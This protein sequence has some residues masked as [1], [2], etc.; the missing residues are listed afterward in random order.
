MNKKRIIGFLLTVLMLVPI[1]ATCV[2]AA[3]EVISVGK[4][5]T[6]EYQTPIHNAYPNKE[7]KPE[8]GLTDG[9]TAAAAKYSDE[10]W[11]E[12]YRGTAVEVTIDLESVMAVT[13]VTIGE[14]QHKSAGIVCSRYLEVYVS[15]NGTDFGFA[16][17]TENETLITDNYTKRVEL[18]ATLDKAYKARYVKV[19]FSSDIFT[20]VDEISVYGSSDS[21]DAA[22]AEITKP[23][24]DKGISGDIDGIKSVCLMYSVSTDYTPELLKPYVAYVDATGKVQ[25]TMFDSLLFLGTPAPT[26]NNGTTVQAD[27]VGFVTRT[28]AEGKNVDALND[29]IGELKNELD[30]GDDY[31][32]PIFISVPYIE[33]YNGA[34][35]EIDGKTVGANDLASR[36]AIVKWYIDYVEQVYSA[37]GYD[38]LELKGFYWMTEAINYHLS[39]HES[40]LAKYFNDYSHEKGYKTMWIPYYSSAG[41][42]EAMDLGFDSVTMQSGYAFDGGEEVGQAKAEVCDDAAAVAKKLGF[43]GIEFEIDVFKTNFAKRFAKYVSAAYHAG[44]MENGM[45]TMYQVGDNLYKSA[46]NTQGVG[47]EVYDLTYEYISGKYFEAVPVIKEGASVTLAVESFANGRL[48]VTDDDNKKNELKIIYVEKP[49]GIF[50]FAEGNGY[51]EVQSFGSQP[52]EYVAK[53]AVTD[54]SNI[55]NTVEIKITVEGEASE[56]SE[57][58]GN[59][60]GDEEKSPLGIIIII[61]AVVAVIGIAAFAVIKIRS[62]K[63]R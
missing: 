43:N 8:K 38:N 21:A 57:S 20:Y 52:G 40:E 47:R 37:G 19:V 18:K 58:Q 31:K 10:A 61:V 59:E 7:Y 54:G 16:G 4:S 53:V 42:D 32:Y 23:D 60:P 46:V 24:A 63:K 30:L 26:G 33:V 35:G 25:D 41:I 50:F 2:N 29:V 17:K 39:T 15:E 45:I 28:F 13:A 9:K 48:E 36:S 55:S 12:L 22:T 5:Y 14:L 6:V 49:E 56:N 3:D 51:Y 62:S 44:V 11:V 34:F 1:C 27:V